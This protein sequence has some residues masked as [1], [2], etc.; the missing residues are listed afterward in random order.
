MA[1]TL[2]LANLGSV[3][4]VLAAALYSENAKGIFMNLKYEQHNN[5]NKTDKKTQNAKDWAKIRIEVKSTNSNANCVLE[6]ID[7]NQT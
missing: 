1:S 5:Q 2:S 3:A 4:F 6:Y 7:M